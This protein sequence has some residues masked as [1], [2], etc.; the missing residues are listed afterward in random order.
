M[1]P[2]DRLDRLERLLAP[3]TPDQRYLAEATERV[4]AAVNR[5]AEVR[6]IE[7]PSGAGVEAMLDQALAEI[8]EARLRARSRP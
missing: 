5:L 3:N 7:P 4:L 8:R 2:A 1:T 6:G